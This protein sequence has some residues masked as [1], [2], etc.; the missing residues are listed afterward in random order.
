MA[1]LTQQ[2]LENELAILE[3]NKNLADLNGQLGET[4]GF[5]STSWELF[6]QAI[7][8]G[9]GGLLPQFK[10]PS[11]ASGGD[12]VK[13]GLFELHAG[14]AVVDK[15]S[16]IGDTNVYITSPTEVLDPQYLATRLAFDR[17]NRRFSPRSHYY[18]NSGNWL[19]GYRYHKY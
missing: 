13:S 12:I 4:Q 19:F 17:R 5:S 14:E 7:F 9:T 6:R 8:N 3:N 18:S 15:S 16:T 11:L 1:D 10:V 2:L